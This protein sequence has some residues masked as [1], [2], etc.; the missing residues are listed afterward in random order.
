MGG[1]LNSGSVQ[2]HHS[3][4]TDKP[5]TSRDTDASSD[6]S[7]PADIPRALPF[8]RIRYRPRTHYDL[9]FQYDVVCRRTL[10]SAFQAGHAG[11]IPVARSRSEPDLAFDERVEGH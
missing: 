8:V 9:L 11:S 7:H 1:Q 6:R 3:N 10:M 2:R 5:T 4:P